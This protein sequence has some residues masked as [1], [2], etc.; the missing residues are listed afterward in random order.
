MNFT[1]LPDDW[2]TERETLRRIGT[3]VVAR[4]EAAVT[5][6]FALMPTAGGFGTPQF[7]PDRTRVRVVGG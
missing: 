3:H 7:G 4:A 6:H 1:A 2:P 5:G